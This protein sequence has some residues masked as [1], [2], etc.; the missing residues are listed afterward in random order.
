MAIEVVEKLEVPRFSLT[1]RDRRWRLVR[2]LMAAEGLD[3]IVTA[4]NTGHWDHFQPNTRYLSGVGGNCGEASVVFPIEGDVTVVAMGIP[5]IHYW[6]GFQD[7]VTDVRNCGRY[8]GR[9][10]VERLNELGMH[11]P[12]ARIGVAGLYNVSRAPEGVMPYGTMRAI[13]NAFPQATFV[14]AT[15]LMERAKYVKSEEEIDALARAVELVEKAIDVMA[16]TAR[17]GVPE[18]EVYAAMIHAMV[19]EGGE[20]PTMLQWSAGPEPQGNNIMPTLRKLRNG[21]IVMNEIEAR[22]MG[23]VGQGVQPMF[24]GEVP[25]VWHEIFETCQEIVQ[26]AYKIFKPG[27][28]IG[29]LNQW[30]LE[31]GELHGSPFMLRP[32]FHGRGLGDDAPISVRSTSDAHAKWALKEN[33]VFILKPTVATP[34]GRKRLYWGDCVVCT[35]DGARRL[36]KRPTDVIRVK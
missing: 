22:W 32:L 15:D 33:T 31:W 14:D 9:G 27:I 10:I 21:D 6:L 8:F 17:P 34:D 20:L 1:E 2:E 25:A 30:V 5:P 3:A 7:W 29:E 36:G 12:G 28:T 24:I 13:E 35:P 4:V 23:Y 19:K 26:D 11:R 18:C 16:A